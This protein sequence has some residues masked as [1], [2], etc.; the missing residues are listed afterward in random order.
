M[1]D[2][3]LLKSANTVLLPAFANT[4]LSKEVKLFLKNGGCSILIGE[5]REEYI[6][7]KMSNER[8]SNETKAILKSLVEEAKSYQKNLIVAIDQEIYG[9]QRLHELVPKFPTLA[10]LKN[11]NSEDFQLICSEI[12]REAKSIGINC[13]LAPILDVVSGENPWLKNRTWSTKPNEISNLSTEFIKGIQKEKVIATAKHF[14]GFSDIKLDPAIEAAAEMDASLESIKAGYLPFEDAIKNK[15][16]M[17]M[18]GP[19]IVKA[20]DKLNPAC[21]SPSIITVLRNELKFNGIILSDDL[22][23]KA[24]MKNLD[25][26]QVAIRALQAGCDFLLLA[27]IEDQ[28]SRVANTIKEAA[29]NGKID[30]NKLAFS[31]K[32]VNLLAKKY[33]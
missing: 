21:L 25:I 9:I 11:I 3:E 20:I 24:T 12:A 2:H 5:S 16:E 1:K 18:V 32:K 31:A 8:K 23:A 15:V 7:R 26:E 29:I 33:T 10:E 28:I 19:A 4:T 22:D 13:F 6:K 17:V 27:D 30:E 14:P